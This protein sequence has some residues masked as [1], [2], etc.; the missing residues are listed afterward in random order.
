M[1]EMGKGDSE[2]GVEWPAAGLE[3]VRTTTH[4]GHPA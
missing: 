2:I 1:E 4:A 3:G